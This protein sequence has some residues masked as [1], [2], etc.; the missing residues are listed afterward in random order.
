MTPLLLIGLGS[1]LRGDDAAG[2]LVARRLAARGLA[3]LEVRENGGDAIALAAE[4]ARCERAVV[5]D[6][7]SG[8]MGAGDVLELSPSELRETGRSSSHGLG[9]RDALALS[10]LLGGAPAV[11]V[12][13][14][15]G[16][17]FGLGDQPSREVVRAAE[18]VAQRLEEEL[19]CA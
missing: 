1:E 14:I 5:I 12:I 3:W 9:L 7:V 6:A 8:S 15:G 18:V 11:R 19:A 10:E 17:R 4:L 2:L 16:R 13:G